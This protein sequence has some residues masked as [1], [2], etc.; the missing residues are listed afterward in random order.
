MDEEVVMQGTLGELIDQIE[1]LPDPPMHQMYVLYGPEGT[2]RF[3]ENMLAAVLIE[4]GYSEE[5]DPL[6]E[7][8][9]KHQ[10]EPV[11][12]ISLVQDVIVSAKEQKPSVTIA[13]LIDALNYF[14]DYDAFMEFED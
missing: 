10:L 7:F 13:E 2:I 5:N 3:A 11:A 8:A 6:P 14:F 12:H 1:G 4:S 9:V